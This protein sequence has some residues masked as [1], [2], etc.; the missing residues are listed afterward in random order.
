[1]HAHFIFLKIGIRYYD[2]FYLCSHSLSGQNKDAFV[3]VAILSI[4]PAATGNAVN[5]A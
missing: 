1:M 5:V 4:D 2:M 3:L